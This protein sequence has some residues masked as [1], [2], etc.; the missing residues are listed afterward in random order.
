VSRDGVE[1]IL[2]AVTG[3]D[4]TFDESKAGFPAIDCAKAHIDAI[5]GRMISGEHA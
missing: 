5:V 4:L 1:A 2:L 3:L